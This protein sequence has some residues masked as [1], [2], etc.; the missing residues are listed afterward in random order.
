MSDLFDKIR[1]LLNSIEKAAPDEVEEENLEYYQD[2][3][4]G[5]INYY[6][7]VLNRANAIIDRNKNKI[8]IDVLDL[9]TRGEVERAM[10]AYTKTYLLGLPI[11]VE[12]T[13]ELAQSLIQICKTY[14]LDPPRDWVDVAQFNTDIGRVKTKLKYI[15]E[16]AEM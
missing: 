4:E 5:V 7:G 16:V 6:E 9:N 14:K 12:A 3:I 15:R 2:V 1:L 8:F 13:S 10:R 11:S